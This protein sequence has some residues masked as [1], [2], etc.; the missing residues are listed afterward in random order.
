M[1]H[2]SPAPPLHH[3]LTVMSQIISV[4]GYGGYRMVV[5]LYIPKLTTGLEV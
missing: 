2:V 3:P 4:D 5:D 1:R